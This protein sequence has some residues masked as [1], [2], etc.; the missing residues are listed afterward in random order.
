MKAKEFAAIGNALTAD[1]PQAVVRG[2]MTFLVPVGNTLRG[3]HF[4]GSSF[5]ADSFYIWW[6]F[7]PLFV[8]T[9]VVHFSFGNRI[10]LRSGADR[11]NRKDNDFMSELNDGVRRDA[12]PVLRRVESVGGMIEVL[13][14]QVAR[15]GGKSVSAREA[16]AYSL[17]FAGDFETAKDQLREVK[18]SLNLTIP[19]QKEMGE[20]A[21]LLSE[22]LSHGQQA[23]ASQLDEWRHRTVENLKLETVG[24]AL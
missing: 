14:E 15:T 19:W 21:D 1:L 3:L 24:A 8:P 13:Q 17:A 2:P 12:L 22:R 7:L 11:W 10:R 4:E 5:D 18:G 20:R 9:D 16:L 23:V 6:F